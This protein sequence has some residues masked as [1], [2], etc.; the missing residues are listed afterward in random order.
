[1]RWVSWVRYIFIV[2]FRYKTEWNHELD[3]IA[4]AVCELITT[5]DLHC[6]ILCRVFNKNKKVFIKNKNSNGIYAKHIQY[7]YSIKCVKSLCIH[8]YALRIYSFIRI[9]EWGLLVLWIIN[10]IYY[11]WHPTISECSSMTLVFSVHVLQV[12]S[13]FRVLIFK[14]KPIHALHL[15][16]TT[17]TLIL[18]LWAYIVWAVIWLVS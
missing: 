1:M 16:Y 14:E 2:W 15:L 10:L 3:T 5:A 17:Y 4:G 7:A 9:Y 11:Y 8:S 12:R 6:S 18:T 13:L